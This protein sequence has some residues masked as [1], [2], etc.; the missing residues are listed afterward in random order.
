[1]SPEKLTETLEKY[2]NAIVGFI[3]LQSIAFAFT[4]GTNVH[5]SCLIQAERWLAPGL[6]AHFVVSSILAC[7]ALA[8]IGKAIQRVD[9]E[10]RQLIRKV[11]WAKIVVVVLFA[12]LPVVLLSLY[13]LDRSANFVEC[14]KRG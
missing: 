9:G 3:V 2:S 4:Q 10:L 1:M 8:M 14:I 13:G 11:Y 7:I 5:F 12:A 6:V